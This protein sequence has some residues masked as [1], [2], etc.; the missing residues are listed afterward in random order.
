MA[1]N[2]ESGTGARNWSSPTHTVPPGLVLQAPPT[3][4]GRMRQML[5]EQPYMHITSL[6]VGRDGL[7]ISLLYTYMPFP[8]SVV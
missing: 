1:E 2:E 4:P 6:W 5:K 3:A 8:S 7:R